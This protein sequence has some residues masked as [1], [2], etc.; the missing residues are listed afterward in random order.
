[1][2]CGTVKQGYRLRYKYTR[3]LLFILTVHSARKCSLRSLLKQC[4]PT[5]APV[6]SIFYKHYIR[7]FTNKERKEYN[8]N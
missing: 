6:Q 1:M 3:E 4:F 2:R 5:P 7:V 8:I